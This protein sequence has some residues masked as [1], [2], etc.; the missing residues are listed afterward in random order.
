MKQKLII[1]VFGLVLMVAVLAMATSEGDTRQAYGTQSVT[2]IEKVAPE[3][4]AS[5]SMKIGYGNV[6][7][8]LNG[9]LDQAI[10]GETN[11]IEFWIENSEEVRAFTL[12]FE[13][14]I[15]RDFAFDPVHGGSGH[16]VKEWNDAIGAFS[17]FTGLLE[18]PAFNDVNPDSILY[19]G[20]SFIGG[21]PPNGLRLCYTMAVYIPSGQASLP[22]GFCIDN[23]FF[24]EAGTWTFVDP[25]GASIPPY[26]QWIPNTSQTN[27]DAPP[28]CFDIVADPCIWEPGD[29]HKMHY[30]QLPDTFG[31]GWDVVS[32]LTTTPVFLADDWRCSETGWVKD[33]HFW[34]GW[35][36][37]G[38]GYVGQITSFE[39]SIW[40]DIPADPPQI[41]YSRPGEKLW[42]RTINAGY[43]NITPKGPGSIAGWYD[44]FMP[45]ILPDDHQ[46][47]FQYDICLDSLDWFY[48]QFGTIYWLSIAATTDDEQ[49]AVWGW[50]TTQDHWNDDAVWGLDPGVEWLD[51]WDP[52]QE[53][54]V[55]LDLA[56]V[57]TGDHDLC[58][59]P[60][61]RGN[62]DY[63]LL[64]EINIADLTYLVSYLFT[65][66]PPPP[67]FEEA[68][69]DG[70]GEINIA[71]LTHLVSYLFSGGQPPWPCP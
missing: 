38:V 11:I 71:D 3:P 25:T 13:F 39:L 20:N 28:V 37:G 52:I 21:L 26:Y 6:I 51:L 17:D 53:P 29:P 9:G 66:G 16:Y 42:T 12:G 70:S 1:A 18:S 36:Y 15:G 67:C 22:N 58:C 49:S 57:I 8:S 10:I 23:I 68:D 44:P 60:P 48:Q 47:Y 41:P 46:G 5:K 62:V 24:P 32:D 59:I 56:F 31:A 27:P 33:I 61:I 2:P 34:G 40:A 65:G 30:P 63:D 35:W 43:F 50:R 7:V 45:Y 54:P 4:E 64:D 14:S 55:S 69:I 19:G